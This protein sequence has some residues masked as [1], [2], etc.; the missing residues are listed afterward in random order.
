ML[1][2]V[3][4]PRLPG[5]RRGYS[6]ASSVHLRSSSR[7]RSARNLPDTLTLAPF[8]R[9]RIKIPKISF[10]PM[11]TGRHA[12]ETHLNSLFVF[13]LPSMQ[14]P[15]DSGLTACYWCS[16]GLSRRGPEGWTTATKRN[17]KKLRCVSPAWK[18][19]PGQTGVAVRRYPG[20]ISFPPTGACGCF[21]GRAP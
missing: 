18:A 13:F 5:H 8:T 10:F 6:G 14:L 4:P 15:L 3:G 21:S 2:L 19:P 11:Q 12:G 7:R 20:R 17:S 1:P 16:V 9:G